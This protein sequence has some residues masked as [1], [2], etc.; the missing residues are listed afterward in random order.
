[1]ISL[2]KQDLDIIDTYRHQAIEGY[3]FRQNPIEN[4]LQTWETNKKDMFKLLGNQI[5]ISKEVQIEKNT[6]IIEQQFIKKAQDSSSAIGKFINNYWK[7]RDT[8]QVD[9]WTKY[10]I[11]YV[12]NKYEGGIQ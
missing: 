4:I 6:S 11:D 12:D 5:S 2:I 7:I 9:R 10:D 3:N 8:I 1:M